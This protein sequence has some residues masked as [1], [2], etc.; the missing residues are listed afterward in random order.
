M[1]QDEDEDADIGAPDGGVDDIMN[2]FDSDMSSDEDGGETKADP[3]LS[4]H[5]MAAPPAR[6]ASFASVDQRSVAPPAAAQ[7]APAAPIAASGAAPAAATVP[8]TPIRDDASVFSAAVLPSPTFSR[9]EAVAE[10][11]KRVLTAG[12]DLLRS[13]LEL[14]RRAMDQRHSQSMS[15]FRR[16]HRAS[17]TASA[18]DSA[19]IVL[20][21]LLPVRDFPNA[22]TYG[23]W[24][25]ICAIRIPFTGI[26][27]WYDISA[28]FR[29]PTSWGRWPTVLGIRTLWFQ[30][31]V[32]TV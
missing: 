11:E 18:A 7:P 2:E 5:L 24:R 14:K 30:A 6:F 12:N 31:L 8:A 21:S 19:G 4:V 15:R 9:M 13:P 10:L 17:F 28:P 1:I 27:L 26:R 32:T 29:S 25:A 20:S 3:G 22:C 23:A 16:K